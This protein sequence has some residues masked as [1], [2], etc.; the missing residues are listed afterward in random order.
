MRTV[1]DES[2]RRYLL[3][4]QS[5]EAGRVRD[6]TTGEERHLPT[7]ELTVVEGESPLETA[8]SGV[9]SAVRRVL[10]AVH[11][12]RSLGLLIEIVDRGR[13]SIRTLL[14]EYDLCESDLHGLLAEFRA[15]GLL[16]ETRVAGE[17]GYA[18][19]DRAI[20]G[21]GILLKDRRLGEFEPDPTDETHRH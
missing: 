8:A 7:E 11:D 13:M 21:I 15:A 2:G 16:E 20:D 9:P 17:R 1:E 10:T 14:A 19:T 5:K 6:P 3:V 4:K 18:P 12:D